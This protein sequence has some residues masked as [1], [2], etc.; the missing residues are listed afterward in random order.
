[1]RTS[2]QDVE[3]ENVE[4]RQQPDED[5]PAAV[6]GDADAETA[7]AAVKRE[8]FPVDNNQMPNGKGM[9]N[10]SSSAGNNPNSP[11]RFRSVLVAVAAVLVSTLIGAILM[12]E[13]DATVPF[14]AS[15]HAL[16]RL[17]HLHRKIYHPLQTAVGCSLPS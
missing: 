8:L 9:Q 5:R 6:M 16:P 11:S 12:F 13:F 14:S 3:S 15:L 10:T 4:L 2:P 17:S 7:A 1:M